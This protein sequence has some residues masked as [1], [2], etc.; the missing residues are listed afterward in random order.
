MPAAH[1]GEVFFVGPQRPI[2]YAVRRVALTGD[3]DEK[4]NSVL[5]ATSEKD[6]ADRCAAY[7]TSTDDLGVSCT[8]GMKLHFRPEGKPAPP[9]PLRP[10]FFISPTIQSEPLTTRSSGPVPVSSRHGTL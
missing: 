4:E 9:L 10:D 6:A 5:H 1:C 2:P 3:D 7:G 8:F